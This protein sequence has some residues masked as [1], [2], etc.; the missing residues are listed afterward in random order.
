MYFVAL[1]RDSEI[2][3]HLDHPVAKPISQ[4]LALGLFLARNFPG[5]GVQH[6]LERAIHFGRTEFLYVVDH[7]LP[8]LTIDILQSVHQVLE[9]VEEIFSFPL[10]ELF[11]AIPRWILVGEEVEGMAQAPEEGESSIPE[12]VSGRCAVAA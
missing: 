11:A 10:L 3:P 7:V 4:L 5:R 1:A 8:G 12:A 9:P 2:R 6:H